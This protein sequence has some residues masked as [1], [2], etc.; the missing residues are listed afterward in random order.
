MSQCHS[1][2]TC[3]TEKSCGHAE[4]QQED[5]G[6]TFAEDLLCLAKSAKHELLKDKMKVLLEAKIGKKLDKV[7]AAA[8]DAVLAHLQHTVAQKHACEQYKENLMAAFK[9]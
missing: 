4:N 1:D 7:A 6:C 2:D 8:V 3:D 9:S 5:A